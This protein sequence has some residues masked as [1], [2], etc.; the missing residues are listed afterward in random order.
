MENV[1][2]IK[3]NRLNG[4]ASVEVVNLENE[5]CISTV[6]GI[7]GTVFHGNKIFCRGLSNLYSPVKTDT[8]EIEKETVV[9]VDEASN[10]EKIQPDASSDP[11]V[12][13]PPAKTVSITISSQIPGLPPST[14]LTKSQAKKQRKKAAEAAKK[15]LES[16]PN[17]FLKI[18]K[19]SKKSLIM[20]SSEFIFG[21]DESMLGDDEHYDTADDDNYGNV[22]NF[23]SKFEGLLPKGKRVLS[24]EERIQERSCRSRKEKFTYQS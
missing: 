18:P 10:P 15:E 14:P 17:S 22:S 9:K 3:I 13:S 12:S 8:P 7:N 5:K 4:K 19:Q 20:G 1:T 23:V 16:G 11:S 21:D 6:N 2:D 24:P